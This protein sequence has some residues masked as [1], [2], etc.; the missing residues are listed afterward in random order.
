M[1]HPHAFFYAILVSLGG[2]VFG[3]DASVISGVVGFV[4]TEFSL[5]PWQTGLVVGSP[6]LGAIIASATA[7]P[8]SDVYGRRKI[9]LIIAFLYVFS[10]VISAFAPSYEVLVL[11]RF[12]G[13]LAFGSLMLAPI[14]IAE[15]S[16]YK[17][18]GVMVSINQLNIVVGFSAAYFANYLLLQM[19][20]S[21]SSLIVFLGVDDHTWRWMLGLETLPALI[22]FISLFFVPESPRWLAL[23]GQLDKAKGIMK[24]L[25][26]KEETELELASLEASAGG[27]KQGYLERMKQLFTPKL[28][29]ALVIGVIIGLIQ[30]VTGVN[31][32]YFY[33]PS[34]FEQS[35]VGKDAAFAQAIWVGLV[36]VV[37]TIVAMFIIDKFGRKPLLL[38]GLV[39]VFVSLTVCAYGFSQATYTLDRGSLETL[40]ENVEVE[41]LEP[42][43]GKTFN[44]DVS[45]KNAIKSAL[46]ESTFTEHEA[47][48]IQ[49]S[50]EVN[51]K[52]VLFGLLGFVAAF[53]F[54][55]GPV[56][57]VLLSEIFPNKLRGV[58]MSFV[59]VLNSSASFTVQFVFP[60]ELANL[61]TAATFMIYAAFAVVGFILMYRLLPE[62]KGRTLEEIEE[63]L[64]GKTA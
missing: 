22:F 59:A 30:Q 9:L 35:G 32:I 12:V 24:K 50:I 15:I 25:L 13:G 49:E 7:S 27:E 48:I 23:N 53:A 10:A 36:N 40:S 58:A 31:A 2:F 19:S 11:A 44:D 45:F 3:F 6:T 64:T 42:L 41:S 28:R 38:A 34:I 54:S 18:R 5:N 4:Q 57:W 14:Y 61:G 51:S 62:T 26:G 55:L 47:Q 16:P 21:D 52:L 46:G 37:F 33:A 1:S 20:K 60:W 8:L 17:L 43:L 56:M 63:S 39:S 29:L